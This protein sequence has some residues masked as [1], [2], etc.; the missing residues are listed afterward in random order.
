MNMRRSGKITAVF[1]VFFLLAFSLSFFSNKT[2][3]SAAEATPIDAYDYSIE[4][5]CI[6][7][8]VFAD[9]TIKVTER[10]HAYFTGY[11]SHGMIRDLPL[12]EGVRYKDLQAVCENSDDFSPY[13]GFDD[14][15]FL[16]LYLRGSGVVRGQER[17]Y[18]ITYTM[19]VPELK[20]SGYL[21]L[22]II[23][24][25]RGSALKNVSACIRLPADFDCNI[26]SG[27]YNASSNLL[28]VETIRDGNTLSFQTDYLSAYQ[29]VTIDFRFAEGVLKANFDDSILYALG[30]GLLI[31]IAALLV[32]FLFCKQPLVTAMVNL[33]A[34]DKMDPLLMGKLI[35][36]KVDSEDLGALVFYLADQGYLTIDLEDKDD[37]EL[38]K[39]DKELP[40]DVPN[41]LKIFYNG[42]FSNRD[43]TK[44]S[45][46]SY[47][48]YQ[49]SQAVKASAELA[50]GKLYEGRSKV[51]LG[52]FAALTVLI[53]GGFG[54]LFGLISVFS[55]YFYW[56]S[57]VA[58]LLSVILS[59]A[60]SYKVAQNK[61]KW[62]KQ[63]QIF[64]LLGS[65]L[66]SFVSCFI[67]VIVKSAAFGIWTSVILI[68]FSATVGQ[69]SGR[70]LVRT[71]EYSAK[72]GQILGFKQFILFTERDKIEFMLQENPELYY[73]VL[74][75]AQTLGVTDAWTEKFKDLNVKAPRYASGYSF[76]IFDLMI[77]N[78]LF[79]SLHSTLSRNMIARPSSAGR[80]G[81][82]GGSFGGGFGGGGF[83]G[84][85]MRGC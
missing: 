16:S 80:G 3:V 1:A 78:N 21:P 82:H 70:F 2:N 76:D 36:N 55:G 74:P 42:L 46:L 9:R 26:Y 23:N 52:V 60:G 45:E 12:E 8:T 11:S 7:M 34:P 44:V 65:F 51:L 49:T 81:R 30:L 25:G 10:I 79:H 5:Y 77:F 48:F 32:K 68:G 43:K 14:P 19:S 35:D 75:Y 47:S 24:Y 13:I 73:H 62:S 15:Q 31:V 83:G 71:Q 33:E 69:I 72:L 66:L 56:G 6:E 20:E 37:P 4:E 41:H 22:N 58:C 39:T 84:G 54:F 18:L 53:L 85:G 38:R 40:Q 59:T 17:L 64:Y 67:P 57:A 61:Y 28:D 29:G 27:S 50:S 63:K